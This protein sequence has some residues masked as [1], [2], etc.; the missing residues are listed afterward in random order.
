MLTKELRERVIAAGAHERQRR[1]QHERCLASNAESLAAAV[2]RNDAAQP[3]ALAVFA[4]AVGDEASELRQLMIEAE[5]ESLPL[6]NDAICLV[7]ESGVLL[8][9][10]FARHMAARRVRVSTAHELVRVA[11]AAAVLNLE[12]AIRSGCLLDKIAD[13]LG[14]P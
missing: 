5:L 14:R 10:N 11:G 7:Q 9:D 6:G 13:Q 4:W 1:A 12:L 8:A 3:Y 2:R